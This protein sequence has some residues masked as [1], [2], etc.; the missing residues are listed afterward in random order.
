[1]TTSS[2]QT[3]TG[4]G[5]RANA[6]GPI[7]PIFGPYASTPSTVLA[8]FGG[9]GLPET[10]TTGYL[11]LSIDNLPSQVE[12]NSAFTWIKSRSAATSHMLFD[13]VRGAGNY[14][15]S[16]G[17]AAEVYDANSLQQFFKGGA[18]IGNNSNINTAG[19]TYVAWNW[20]MQS[21]GAGVT[22]TD[23]S[24]TSTVLAD[25]TA[26]FSIVTYTGTGAN[27]TIGHGLGSVPSMIIIKEYGAAGNNWVVYNSV[28][29]NQAYIYLNT[30]SA[31]VTGSSTRWNSTSPTSSV[32]SVGT[33]DETNKSSSLFVAYCFAPIAGFSAFGSYTG[34]G[35]ADGPFI[36]TGFKPTFLLVKNTTQASNWMLVDIARNSYNPTINDL[37]PNLSDT[38][39][40]VTGTASFDLNSN[41]F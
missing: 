25:T 26:G 18:L 16:T 38:E 35:S 36:Y 5:I 6:V 31:V 33:I 8:N 27:A 15:S 37:A 40:A 30:T 24:I 12:Y 41:G 2:P 3:V 11:T 14:I 29:G 39:P 23:G 17:T 28:S 9:N 7:Y 4:T 1:M 22:N 13:R 34:N 21:T 32:F 20:F 19:A 10:P